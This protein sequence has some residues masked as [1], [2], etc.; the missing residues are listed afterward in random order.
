M[1][2]FNIK[3]VN[4]EPWSRK[5]REQNSDSIPIQ[6]SN[7]YF[8]QILLLVYW[9]AF[10]VKIFFLQNSREACN[11]EI[12]CWIGSN[13][14]LGVGRSR[15]FILSLQLSRRLRFGKRLW[16]TAL[17]TD[18]LWWKMTFYGRQ[19]LMEDTF[20]E[21]DLWWKTNFDARRPLMEDYLWWETIFDGRRPFLKD[22][23]DIKA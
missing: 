3:R 4:I 10:A 12:L 18:N 7:Q 23:G 19:P 11:E 6:Y 1:L 2:L 14:R 13:V 17:M 16:N 20:D 22:E 8:V 15:E 9:D 5:C 21:E